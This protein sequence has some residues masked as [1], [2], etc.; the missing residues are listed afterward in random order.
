MQ[1]EF[2]QKNGIQHTTWS[3]AVTHKLV[4]NSSQNNPP[5]MQSLFPLGRTDQKKNPRIPKAT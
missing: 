5:G 3:L 2:D 1:N 4:L